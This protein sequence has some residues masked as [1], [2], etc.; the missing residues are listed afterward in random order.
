MEDPDIAPS[1]AREHQDNII[2]S[3]RCYRFLQQHDNDIVHF[4]DYLGLG[5]YTA[6]ARRQGLIRSIVIT[7]THGSSEWVRR[8][9]LALPDLGNLET[10]ALERSQ[11]EHSDLVISPSR[12][13]LEWYTANGATLPRRTEVINWILPDWLSSESGS[14]PLC[15]RALLPESTRELIF[16]GRHERRKGIENFVDA[17]R[18]LQHRQAFDV[19]FLGRFD[20]IDRENSVGYI[21]RNLRDFTG[22]LRFLNGYDPGQALRYIRSRSHALCVLPSLIENSPCTVGEAFS[23]G[24]PFIAAD[25]GGTR[26]LIDPANANAALFRSDAA[27][28]A[29]RLEEVFASGLR[30]VSSTLLPSRIIQTWQA[31]HDSLRPAKLARSKGAARRILVPTGPLVSVCLVHHERPRLLVRALQ[32]LSTQTYNNIEIILVDDG[33]TSPAA[34]TALDEIESRHGGDRFKVIRSPNRYLGAARNLAASVARGDFLMFHDDDNV[35]EPHEIE[36]FVRAAQAGT[37]EVLTAQSYVFKEGADPQTGKIEF[38][39]IGIGGT[40]SFFANRFGDA[41]ALVSRAA[42]ENVGG[43]TELHGVGWE[44]WEFF[45]KAYLKGIRIG[46]VPMPL[47]RYQSSSTG[48]LASGSPVRNNARI[49]D[50]VRNAKPCLTT[51]LLQLARRDNVAQQILDQTWGLLGNERF[52][53]LHRE[54]MPLD[55]NSE[56]AA[57]KI[58]DLAFHLGRHEDAVELG[59]GSSAMRDQ[60]HR[61]LIAAGP[62]G[63]HRTRLVPEPCTILPNHDQAYELEG[64]L[65]TNDLTPLRIR[66]IRL[67]TRCFEIDGYEATAR[68][69]V[70]ANFAKEGHPMVGFKLTIGER[71]EAAMESNEAAS[72]IT[73]NVAGHGMSRLVTPITVIVEGRHGADTVTG[74]VET[75]SPVYRRLVRLPSNGSRDFTGHVEFVIDPQPEDGRGILPNECKSP[76]PPG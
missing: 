16:F 48:M 3:Y 61:L 21:L 17:L 46:I 49:F 18:R 56:E 62:F 70:A 65:A 43:F 69:D 76:D 75:I 4:H 33:S 5:F 27:G 64:W 11:I 60:L 45:L 1:V 57:T 35:A 24:A 55:P 31:L 63:R 14:E 71:P 38:F 51:D 72:E 10:E 39:P 6:M 52:G 36:T 30:S 74:W 29:Q 15:A 73:L 8:Y 23:I 67:G 68:H 42:F 22:R 2:K 9:N 66:G 58:V 44:D 54:L 28:L 59:L 50:A 37:F 26:E 41:N 53:D 7:Q 32:Q 40:H 25:V 13:M 47:F 20:R 19:T 12:Y 34:T